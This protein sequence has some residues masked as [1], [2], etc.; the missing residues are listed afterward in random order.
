MVQ[1]EVMWRDRG[2]N[3]VAF[4][5]DGWWVASGGGDGTARVWKAATG[6]VIAQMVQ[7]EVVWHDRGVKAV[8][9]SPDG[10][11]V[12]SGSS[13]GAVRVWLWRPEDLIA[14]ACARL[15]RNLTLEEWRQ[16]IPNEPYRPT[17]PN[18]PVPER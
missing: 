15:P 2:V 3:A 12:A 18:L 6:C 5:P 8:A 14:E 10:R 9:F 16:Y 4:S 13:D 17:C 1:E 7:E 11:W